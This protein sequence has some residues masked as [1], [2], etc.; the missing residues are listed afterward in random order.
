MVIF[1]MM[2]VPASVLIA[3]TSFNDTLVWKQ[4]Q[5]PQHVSINFVSYVVTLLSFI[6]HID[7]M[8]LSET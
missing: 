7:N 3:R 2:R 1:Q 6:L 8:L 4:P 5:P